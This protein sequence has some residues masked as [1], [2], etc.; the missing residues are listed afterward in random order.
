MS[1]SFRNVLVVASIFFPVCRSF[2]GEL[3]ARCAEAQKKAIAFLAAAQRSQGGFISYEWL[4]R[5]PDKKHPIETPFTVSQLVYSLGFCG[6]DPIARVIRDR[7]AAWLVKQREEPG[8][9][10]YHGKGDALPPD[11][12]D[13]AM[14]LVALHREG[15]SISPQ[16]LDTL[17]A[18]RDSR[19]LF[20]TWMGDPS[21]PVD[22]RETD[23]VVNLN[24]LLLFGL[25]HENF[26]EVCGYLLKQVESEA[27]RRGSVYYPSPWAFTY[28]FSRAYAD[29]GVACLQP[30]LAKVREKTLS[31]QK[32]DGGWGSEYE[33]VLALL[34]LLNLGERGPA[35]EKALRFLVARQDS[36]GGWIFEPAYTGADRSMSYGSRAVTASLCIE[37]FAKYLRR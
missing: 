27:F 16:T 5:T 28:A 19:N 20:N 35:V 18:N 34:T 3:E 2:A 37:A 22:S 14:A 21:A 12:D 26:E 15:H 25:V 33:T 32:S 24:V 9:W 11:A 1:P 30:A 4:T 8:V 17:R 7:A 13:T 29:G 10:R 6:D 31:L 36:D 23:A